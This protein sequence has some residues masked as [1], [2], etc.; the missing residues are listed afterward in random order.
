MRTRQPLAPTI[1][2]SSGKIDG[3]LVAD[4]KQA[5]VIQIPA[6]TAE[7]P[8]WLR[9]DFARP[10]VV[11]S[12]T[13]GTTPRTL[14]GAA[15][16]EPVLEAS[17]DGE[18]FTEVARFPN[19]TSA[20]YTITFPAVTAKALRVR[21]LPDTKGF[22][23]PTAPAPGVE[24]PAF[25]GFMSAG[26]PQVTVSE[27]RLSTAARTHR[28]EEKAGFAT[29]LDYHSLSSPLFSGIGPED[30]HDLTDRMKPDGTLDWTPPKGSWRVLRMGYSLTGTENHP[31]T[32][33]ATGLEVDKFD[34]DAVR[35]YINTY[36]DTYVDAAGADMMGAKGVRA[37]LNDSI[38]VGA[39]NWTPKL[40]E[41][42]K[43]RRGYDP[44]RW[45]PA[46][47]GVMIEG[48]VRTDA[49]LYDF[50]KTLAELMAEAHYRTITAEVHKRGM[51]HYSEAL[52]D[53]RPSLGDD[54]DMRRD[55]D[56]PMAAMWSYDAQPGLP[57][58]THQ[59]DIRGAASVAHIYGQNLVAAESLTSAMSPW[60]FAPRDLKPM[61]DIE[62]ALG[63]N[64]PVIHTSVHQP[65]TG[66]APGF[67]LFIFGQ[68]FNRLETW[69]EQAGPWVDYIARSSYMLQQGR[70]VADV[71]YFYGE[72]APITA[73]FAKATPADLP[74]ANAFDFVNPDVLLNQLSN[75]GGDLV[76]KSGARYKVLYL[77]GSSRQMSLP[78]LK[79]IAALV[80]GGAT[81]V[82][83]K[84]MGGPGLMDHAWEFAPIAD[85]LWGGDTGKGRVIAGHDPDKALAALGIAPDMA[86]TKAAADTA[87]LFVHRKTPDADIYYV[88]N[89]K[90]R[91]EPTTLTF[92]VS[93]KAPEWWDAAT[94][95]A[96]PLGYT[97]QDG[98]TS[99]TLTLTP[100]QS[101]FVVFREAGAASRAVAKPSRTPVA[102]LTGPWTVTFQPGRG[103]PES[104]VLPQLAD[105][106]KSSD[107]GVRYFSGT[108]TLSPDL[109]AACQG[110]QA[111]RP[112][113]GRSARGG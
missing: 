45:L 7:A 73:L 5:T 92:P 63:V 61:I 59:G 78:V 1:S 64:R 24:F 102:A 111:P 93:G 26:P 67:S 39:S 58:P 21:F 17:T 38:E 76:A 9:A 30:V 2:A 23:L 29:A 112:R 65:L 34:A 60:A 14:F 97:A 50:R 44:V 13:L 49:F 35:R 85:K 110:W 109:Q 105:W 22:S 40:I 91:A 96:K 66:K 57:Q 11:R 42:F 54:M 41:E 113:S 70:N 80:R 68:Y 6:G 32:P 10:Q 52:E 90:D 87:L 104:A 106:S 84:P 98:R 89:R 95:T 62:F 79:R 69:G 53:K 55:A 86:Y 108:A 81:L 27:F 103:A 88:T 8:G 19:G 43:A 101:G 28:V 77:G 107:P 83:E 72:E 20:E 100:Y 94:G 82:G 16:F 48:S 99:I 37:L 25:P 31:A 18:T 71:A 12:A 74:T 75:D 46:L 56:V 47:T 33:E 15:S 4:G 36:L 51:I 3:A